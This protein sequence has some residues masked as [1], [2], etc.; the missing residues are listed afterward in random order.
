MSWWWFQRKSHGTAKV[1]VHPLQT[2]TVQKF[3]EIHSI[4]ILIDIFLSKVVGWLPSNRQTV[5]LPSIEPFAKI[6]HAQVYSFQVFSTEI[7]LF[8]TFFNTATCSKPD[9]RRS[10]LSNQKN[11]YNVQG[12]RHY[13]RAFPRSLQ[14]HCSIVL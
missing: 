2:A 7:K 10:V 8:S 5:T 12:C 1:R 14:K 11:N 13:N 3:T 6:K 4:V 9:K